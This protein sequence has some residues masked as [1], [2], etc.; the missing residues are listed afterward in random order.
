MFCPNCGAEIT[1][2][3]QKFC[4]KCGESLDNIE[5]LAS[6][7]LNGN[8]VSNYDEGDY[9]DEP[10]YEAA[11]EAAG[12]YTGD[13][14]SYISG[15]SIRPVAIIA[16]LLLLCAII[17]PII[18]TSSEGCDS[19][20]SSSESGSLFSGKTFVCDICG[21]EKKGRPR[22]AE[23]WGEECEICG[24]CYKDLKDLRDELADYF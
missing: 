21:E 14:R 6:E 17:I 9:C 16:L 7:I 4:I 20:S 18:V 24:D 23:I 1:K 15:T 2:E 11:Y 19:G 10:E 13:N 3:K 8:D 12:E 22:K 5:S